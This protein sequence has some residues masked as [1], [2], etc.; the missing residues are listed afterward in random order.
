MER[1]KSQDPPFEHYSDADKLRYKQKVLDISE[2]ICSDDDIMIKLMDYTLKKMRYLA[3]YD[4]INGM[5]AQDFIQ[6]A[7]L[8][9][10]EGDRFW[11]GETVKEL[12]DHY[13]HIIPSLIWNE[14]KK[15]KLVV[16]INDEFGTRKI[17]SDKFV[18]HNPAEDDE[19]EILDIVIN[20]TDTSILD[21]LIMQEIIKKTESCI[22]NELEKNEDYIGLYLYE[23]KI[24][25]EP[26]PH[27]HV[28]K[29]LNI[30][31]EDVRNADKRLKRIINKS[32][33]F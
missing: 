28:A 17:Y 30:A 21:N 29:E 23:A 27:K 13:Y 20:E 31:I 32:K 3:R 10:V 11:Q 22:Y 24:N 14:L 16:T 2:V 5:E 33:R 12:L 19:K 25:G 18:R 4:S 15:T 6:E 9:T 1:K 26:N 8:K 7:I